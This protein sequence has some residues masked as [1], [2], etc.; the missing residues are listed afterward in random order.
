MEK[1]VSKM[2]PLSQIDV[3]GGSWLAQGVDILLSRR[4]ECGFEDAVRG[5]GLLRGRVEAGQSAEVGIEIG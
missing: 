4:C 1:T 2:S 5:L 3:L